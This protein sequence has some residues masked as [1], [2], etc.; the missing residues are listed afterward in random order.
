MPPACLL[1][2]RSG[3]ARQWL[4]LSP[5]YT[6]TNGGRKWLCNFPKV[7]QLVSGRAGTGA[8]AGWLESTALLRHL[9]ACWR[10]RRRGEGLPKAELSGPPGNCA[11]LRRGSQLGALHR[12]LPR[13]TSPSL[14]PRLPV[15]FDG[16]PSATPAFLLS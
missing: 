14:T 10:G 16:S 9:A 15:T 6:R 11:C 1:S 7:S 4:L 12:Q 8:Q 5:F 3:S 13:C 2:L